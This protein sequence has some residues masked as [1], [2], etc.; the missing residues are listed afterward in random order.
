[1]GSDGATFNP[2]IQKEETLYFF[3][4][5]LCR[6]MP[7]V[8]D[9]KVTASTLPGYRFV[10]HPD[11][12]MSPKSVPENACYCVDET[13]CEMIGD[14]MFGVSKC[15]QEAP[16]VLSWPHFLHG[17]QR[18]L[19]A[20]DGLR[21]NE[22]KHGFWFDIQQT[23]GTTLAAKARLQINI[24]LKSM[25][26][27]RAMSKIDDTVLPTL[28]FE[29]GIDE[30]GPELVDVIRE[31]VDAPPLYKN[32]LLCILVGIIFALIVIGSVA[33]IRV[34][35]DH[36]SRHRRE[37]TIREVASKLLDMPHMHGGG[38]NGHPGQHG[39]PTHLSAY[40]EEALQPML[41]SSGFASGAT[42]ADGSRVTTATHSRNA[43]DGSAIVN[44]SGTVPRVAAA[45]SIAEDAERERLIV[46]TRAARH[47]APPV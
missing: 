47:S 40:A 31:A 29:E 44:G 34:C 24:A 19:D 13:L 4:D 42:T 30:L 17:E 35:A 36:R 14:G 10:P 9:K 2:Y 20:V 1:M 27:Y 6:A 3:N 45:A 32:Y 38:P 18:F 26:H 33:L 21:P 8:F 37:E 39:V 7:L 22:D 11:V 41:D 28:W 46:T 25:P 5:A 12:F 23:T 15:Q 43:S 16:I